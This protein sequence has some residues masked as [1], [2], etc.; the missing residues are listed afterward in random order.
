[1]EKEARESFVRMLAAEASSRQMR[2]KRGALASIISCC[3]FLGIGCAV[4]ALNYGRSNSWMF[5]AASVVGALACYSQ[6]QR[7]RID[8][9][10][11]EIHA[12]FLNSIDTNDLKDL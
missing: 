2:S 12:A 8:S 11:D 4:V 10:V 1:M 7:L 6:A 9:S 3:I 5:V